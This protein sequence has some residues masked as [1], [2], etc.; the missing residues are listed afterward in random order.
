MTDAPTTGSKT[1]D[2][3]NTFVIVP[4]IDGYIELADRV[5]HLE[6]NM[7]ATG[8]VDDDAPDDTDLGQVHDRLDRHRDEIEEI[9]RRYNALIR[10]LGSTDLAAAPPAASQDTVQPQSRNMIP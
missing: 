10:Y 4:T 2:G 6:A 5:S 1:D 8:D 9:K 3:K 7:P